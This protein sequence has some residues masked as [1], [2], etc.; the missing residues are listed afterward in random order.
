ML[1]ERYI[2]TQDPRFLSVI[3]FIRSHDIQ[4]EAHLNRTRFMLDSR[5]DYYLEFVLR[6]ADSCPSVIS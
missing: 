4:F 5:A 6:Y 1:E 2:L 3:T